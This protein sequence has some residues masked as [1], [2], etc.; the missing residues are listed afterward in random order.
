MMLSFGKQK[1]EPRLTQAGVQCFN[2]GSLFVV[3][4]WTDRPPDHRGQH[5]WSKISLKT[6]LMLDLTSLTKLQWPNLSIDEPSDQF[7][8]I[9]GI[10]PIMFKLK[11]V[12]RLTPV[13]LGIICAASFKATLKAGKFSCSSLRKILLIGVSSKAIIVG[14]ST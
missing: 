11:F 5:C 7:F 12:Y 13:G 14:S 2:S 8:I 1:I 3:G 6:C 4:G 9:T 10:S